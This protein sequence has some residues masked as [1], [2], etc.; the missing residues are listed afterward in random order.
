MKK[1]SIV[2][3]FL[4]SLLAALFSQENNAAK[5]YETFTWNPVSNAKK[6]EVI[7]EK[8]D[9]ADWEPYY[10]TIQK[11]TTLEYLLEPATY[12]I[13]IVSI[14]AVGRKSTQ[15]NWVKFIILDEQ[16]PYL[17]SNY[18]EKNSNWNAPVLYIPSNP[19]DKIP[20]GKYIR[21]GADMPENSL[22]IKG[23]NIFFETTEFALVPI[24]RGPASAKQYNTYNLNRTEVP[25]SIVNRARN[26]NYVIATYNPALLQSG[27]YKLEAR[28]SGHKASY[29]ILVLADGDLF[30][31]PLELTYDYN[32]KV[33]TVTFN[34]EEKLIISAAG[35]G[36]TPDTD[37]YLEPVDR[38]PVYAFA[39]QNRPEKTEIEVENKVSIPDSD[40]I[41]IE[42]S[43]PGE[44]VRAGYYNVVADNQNGQKQQFPILI[45]S[46]YNGNGQSKVKSVST[47]Y[48]RFTNT[49]D[50]TVKGENLSADDKV[51]LVSQYL[52]DLGT[53]KTVGE[54][55][56]VKSNSSKQL[57]I[58]VPLNEIPIGKYGV[59]V[60]TDDGVI[61]SFIE[62]DEHY[63]AKAL[64]DTPEQA[65]EWI[66]HAPAKEEK[67]DLPAE[68]PKSDTVEVADTTEGSATSTEGEN[69]DRPVPSEEPEEE[70]IEPKIEVTSQKVKTKRFVAPIASTLNSYIGFS[71]TYVEYGGK[72]DF[73][74][75]FELPIL[76]TNWFFMDVGT[77]LSTNNKLETVSGPT[78]AVNLNGNFTIPGEYVNPFIGFDFGYSLYDY[79]TS[80][81]DRKD[82]TASLVA[83]VVV[84]DFLDFKYALELHDVF[85]NEYFFKD[86]V[87]IGMRFHLRDYTFTR[88]I[89]SQDVLMS[90]AEVID[91]SRIEMTLD[92]TSSLSFGD[93]VLVIKN[94]AK[95]ANLKTVKLSSN[96]EEIGENAF[97]SCFELEDISLE[98]CNQLKK[99]GK[100]AFANCIK[101]Q[102]LFIPESV[103][104]IEADAFANWTNG[105]IITLDWPRDDPTP[106]NLDGL[107]TTKASV[108]YLDGYAFENTKQTNPFMLARNWKGTIVKMTEASEVTKDGF[109]KTLH[110]NATANK[111]Y[112]SDLRWA[113]V[114]SSG[115]LVE[116]VKR[117]DVITITGKAAKKSGTKKFIFLV[118]TKDGGYFAASFSLNSKKYKTTKIA[119]KDLKPTS[120]S[121]KKKLDRNDIKTVMIIPDWNDCKDKSQIDADFIEIKAG[122][123]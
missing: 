3:V 99:I 102:E 111:V 108:Y 91:G 121:K 29:A 78:I 41:K 70:F 87:Y 85:S 25:L 48:N 21:T 11:E 104:V 93:D 50:I 61:S 33:D 32:Y 54:N 56:E 63:K 40:K 80:D 18:Y 55:A 37:F 94:L 69:G 86:A 34:G 122:K 84:L 112:K 14:N 16:I 72:T 107:K 76:Q 35:K 52:P 15:T 31:E 30:F 26:Q 64:K 90:E 105:Q 5:I 36:F 81:W 44:E 74:L 8:Q 4:F 67:K 113:N 60:E 83:G 59:F 96:V 77:T 47:K 109:L 10:S 123:K 1:K 73:M 22:Y 88:T 23:K 114:E 71:T 106:R 98:G 12:R 20:E 9:G 27:Y 95:K 46:N 101:I 79:K 39:A 49:V 6:Y 17:F 45:K 115:L 118:G 24:A 62:I 13:G 38:T 53:S 97:R 19:T 2:L 92:K 116:E 43:I 65:E 57:S 51:K 89:L 42:L 68:E 66:L 82:F 119:V 75:K 110:L 117:N 103:T 100:A 120:Y 28:N 58:S 7:I